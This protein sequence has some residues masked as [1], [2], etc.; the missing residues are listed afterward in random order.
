MI[1][2]AFCGDRHVCLYSVYNACFCFL[3]LFSGQFYNRRNKNSRKVACQESRL[4][5]K[6]INTTLQ[7]AL[8]FVYLP[9][10]VSGPQAVSLPLRGTE[11]LLRHELLAHFHNLT[12][13]H[14]PLMSLSN[15]LPNW[16]WYCIFFKSGFCLRK[17]KKKAF[18]VPF[19]CLFYYP[20]YEL[21]WLSSSIICYSS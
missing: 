2:Q 19:S 4:T 20:S 7:T 15:S 5:G 14:S 17:K 12:E 18:S 6:Q 13:H 21:S 10:L 3:F 1:E 11:L 9:E 8:K 16:K